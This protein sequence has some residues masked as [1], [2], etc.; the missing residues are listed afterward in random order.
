VGGFDFFDIE[1]HSVPYVARRPTTAQPYLRLS[2]NGL[3]AVF[4][5]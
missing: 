4:L 1:R 3:L 2:D 5:F